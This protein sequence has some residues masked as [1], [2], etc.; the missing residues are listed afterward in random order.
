MKEQ[1]IG[2]ILRESRVAQHLTLEE[3]EEKPPFHR[4]IC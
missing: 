1:T 2:D 4:L 3:V